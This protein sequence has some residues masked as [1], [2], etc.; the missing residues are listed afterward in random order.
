VVWHVG[1]KPDRSPSPGT[2]RAVFKVLFWKSSV[3]DVRERLMTP[4][5]A[6]SPSAHEAIEDQLQ[7]GGPY[8]TVSLVGDSGWVAG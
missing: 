5:Q 8:G 3:D 6:E 4:S 1:S 2:G 7:S